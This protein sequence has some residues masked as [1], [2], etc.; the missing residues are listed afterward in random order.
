[1]SLKQDQQQEK[2]STLA[3]FSFRTMSVASEKCLKSRFGCW[4][5]VSPRILYTPDDA[6]YKFKFYYYY[7]VLTDLIYTAILK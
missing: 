6:F 7:V 5:R 2:T 3:P 1:M 4:R